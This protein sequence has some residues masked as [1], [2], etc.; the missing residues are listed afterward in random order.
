MSQQQGFGRGFGGFGE[1]GEKIS[2]TPTTRL[3]PPPPKSFRFRV[4]VDMYF[5]MEECPPGHTLL[6][7]IAKEVEHRLGEWDRVKSDELVKYNGFNKTE[8]E[9]LP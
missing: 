9:Q 4:N 6:A 2:S 3:P 1:F 7:S 5:S 8:I